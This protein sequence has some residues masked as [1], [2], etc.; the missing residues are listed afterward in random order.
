M[1]T[2]SFFTAEVVDS[3]C[4]GKQDIKVVSTEIGSRDLSPKGKLSKV[5]D[6]E[7]LLLK[8]DHSLFSSGGLRSSLPAMLCFKNRPRETGSSSQCVHFLQSFHQT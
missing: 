7:L 2:A 5:F 4:L 8:S 6:V 1:F 3:A